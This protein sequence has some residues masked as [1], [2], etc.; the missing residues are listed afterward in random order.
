VSGT[1]RK[2]LFVCTANLD[3]S[4]TAEHLFNGWE[5]R[6]EA[7][8][9][10]IRPSF[11]GNPLSQELVDWADLILAMEPVHS[12]FIRVNYKC[13]PNRVHVLGVSDLYLRDDPELIQELQN[14]VPRILDLENKPRETWERTDRSKA[15]D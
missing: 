3:R 5:G 14:K 4:P 13:D 7:K 10:G 12:Q 1:L 6:W 11:G 2:V 8:S 9:A 15:A